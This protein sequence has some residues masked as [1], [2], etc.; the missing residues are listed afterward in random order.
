MA[1]FETRPANADA[2]DGV[3]ALWEELTY[4]SR[5]L[6][7]DDLDFIVNKRILQGPY[8]HRLREL[9]AHLWEVQ[10]AAWKGWQEQVANGF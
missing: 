2:V 6:R 9:S 8:T 4:S 5:R 3:K 7:E 1:G 10:E